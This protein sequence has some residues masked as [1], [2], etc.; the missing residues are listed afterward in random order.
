MDPVID[1][2]D[3]TSSIGS[4]DF[5]LFLNPTKYSMDYEDST[6]ATKQ[7]SGLNSS[8]RTE[9]AEIQEE[10]VVSKECKIAKE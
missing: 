7:P 5:I 2:E 3:R 4:D 9:Y 6:G 8:H 10:D 1:M